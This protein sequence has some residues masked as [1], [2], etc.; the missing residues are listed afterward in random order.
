MLGPAGARAGASPPRG[1]GDTV[2]ITAV[3][4]E[5][6]S[7]AL[8][9]SVFQTFGAGI[10]EPRT[11]IVL[12]NRGTAFSL[13]PG[14][15]AEI[16]PGRRPPHTLCPLL[17][18]RAARDEGG[19]AAAVPVRAAIGCQGGSAQPLILSQVAA[20]ALDRDA[21]LDAA[22]AQPRWVVGDR[23][24]GYATETVLAEP[25]AE[26][27]LAP[28]LAAAGAP[29]LV[30][31]APREDRCG[32]VQIARALEA[33]KLEAAADPR[34]DGAGVVTHPRKESI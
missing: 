34:A 15:P 23:E 22:L 29:P 1:S 30:V 25:G 12:H 4:A 31:G 13:E 26:A 27:I 9:Q 32:H 2:A 11:G 3:D 7:V 18:E 14:H 8:I 10:L 20:A 19:T 6:R 33:G 17:G 28:E 24:L 5:G 21:S 16:G